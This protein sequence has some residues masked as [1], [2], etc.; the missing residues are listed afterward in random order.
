M[1][2]TTSDIRSWLYSK[3]SASLR[4]APLKVWL[5]AVEFRI[6]WDSMLN[7][8][9]G[10][11]RKHSHRMVLALWVFLA[12]LGTLA[13]AAYPMYVIR[14]FR[15]QTPAALD[16]ALW[17]L[18]HDKPILLVLALAVTSLALLVWRRA[19]WVSR[20]LLAPSI[21]LALIAAVSAWINPYEHMFHP[22]G[23]PHYIAAQQ[24]SLDP[25]DMVIAVTLGG[26]SRAYPIREMGYHHVVNDRLYG[27][28]MVVTY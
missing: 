28:P 17:V 22:F 3:A 14:P 16:R 18:L 26:E 24:A 1:K 20:L 19:G 23:E 25:N 21:L 10:Y 7:A 9:L 15:E 12:S 8:T 4:F 27:L 2:S 6:E 11:L 13:L 5:Q